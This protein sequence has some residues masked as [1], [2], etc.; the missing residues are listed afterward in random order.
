MQASDDFERSIEQ[1]RQPDMPDASLYRLSNLHGRDLDLLAE[2]WSS[3]PPDHRLAIALRLVEIAEADFETDFAEV[4]KICLQDDDARVRAEAIKGL[5]E[6]DDVALIRPLVRLLYDDGS[7]V[8]REATAMS[9]SR[10]ALQAELGQIQPRLADMVWDVLW[11]TIHNLR[12]D[13]DVRRRAVES[14]AYFG[15]PEV[16]EV[17]ER[18]YQDEEPKMRVSAVFAMGRSGDE[19]WTDTVLSELDQDDPEM[20]YEAARACGELCIA[21]AVPVLGRM[22]ADPDGEVKLAAVWAL[23]QIGGPEARRI[24]EICSEMGDEALQDAADAALDELDFMHGAHDLQMYDFAPDDEEEGSE[25]WDDEE[26]VN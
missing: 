22:V 11:E 25:L 24:L 2:A 17:I 15:R 13:T 16:S 8:V 26:E 19:T 23:G 14:L 6:V 1:L 9:L 18:A 12:E 21:E 4:F 5:W 10:F 20:R 7:L 3:F